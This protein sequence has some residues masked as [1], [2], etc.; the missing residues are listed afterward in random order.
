M[1]KI[2]TLG[3]LT[4]QINGEP[5]TSFPS[6]KAEALLVY[7]AV[8]RTTKHR[9]ESLFTL[10]WPGMP[11]KSARHNLRQ[12]LYAL[13][14]TL[15]EVAAAEGDQAVPLLLTDR[16]TVQINPEAAVIIDVQQ[17][18]QILEEIQG[19]EHLNLAGCE[20]CLRVMEE[21]V[22]RYGGEFLSD[23]YLEDSNEFE[24]W[25]QANREAYHQ[26]ALR[27]LKSL[28]G[29]FIQK[30]EYEQA[31]SYAERQLE[32]DALKESAHRQKMEILARCGQRA[33]ALCHYRNCI[34]ILRKELGI[35]PS[36]KTIILSEQ[37]RTES[38][39]A[40]DSHKA[41]LEHQPIPRHNLPHP[42]TS[43][44]GRQKELDEITRLIAN[45][46]LVTLT[47]AG[48]IG[49]TQ[50]CLQAGRAQ[51]AAFSDGV[52]LVEL[53]PIEKPH[54]IPQTIAFALGLW[55]SPSRAILEHLTKYLQD[56]HCLL[57]LD[58]CEHLIEAATQATEAILQSCPEVRI[59]ASSRETLSIPGEIVY[60]VPPLSFPHHDQHLNFE[61]WQQF[62]A[63]HLFAERARDVLA[64]FQITPANLP[65]LARS[66][67]RLDGIPLALELAAA[68]V[69]LLSLEQIAQRLNDRFSL[70]TESSRTAPQRQ[71]TLHNSIEWSW[72]LLTNSEQVLLQRL[73]VFAGGMSLEAVEAVCGS[74]GID[75]GE[76]MNLLSQ[77][78]NKSM[79]VVRREQGQETR[80]R[81]LETIHQYA[82]EKLAET[83]LEGKF[84]DR[85]LDYFLDL[86][87]QAEVELIGP[88]QVAWYSLLEM[89]I[90][91][92]RSA[93]SWSSETNIE[94]GLRLIT[95]LNRF[96]YYGYEAEGEAWIS[97]LLS[98]GTILEPSTR[99][100]AFWV[101]GILTYSLTLNVDLAN[102][103]LQKSLVLYQALEDQRGIALC[104]SQLSI[105]DE[106][107]RRELLWESLNIFRKI[108]DKVGA[109]GALLSLGSGN[110]NQF[111]EQDMKYREESEKL[112]REVG[113][114]TGIS[115]SL[116]VN[117]IRAMYRGE[118][119]IA[120]QFLEEC[121]KIQKLFGSKK[122]SWILAWLGQLY[123]W[124]NDY[125]KALRHLEKSLSIT[126]QTGNKSHHYWTMVKL[127]YVYLR[128]GEAYQAHTIFEKCQEQFKEIEQ[129]SG[130]IFST[131]G[132]ASLALSQGQA[133]K[134][135][136]LF[137]WADATRL[138]IQDTRPPSS[139]PM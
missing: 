41:T 40:S 95:S 10:L 55:E 35:A 39:P 31:R 77:L 27:T 26:K 61:D 101:Q 5:I 126:Q 19:H 29:I 82:A 16:H 70:L 124:K 80:Y 15:G 108:G 62:D 28:T 127:G 86:A 133:E 13:R 32:M 74:D 128:M 99:A 107:I 72:E 139:K 58:N 88:D 67:Q 106:N 34:E 83:K 57:L 1:L 24:D 93:L 118:F 129:M 71:Q 11:E 105:Y 104:W 42:L 94:A 36:T 9:R 100:K 138:E 60:L 2:L 78:V 38:L 117:G 110:I 115:T 25:V 12:V 53:A 23:F 85:H 125:Q 8:E 113:H 30:G 6:H 18:D 73:S 68:R 90:D 43:F 102:E 64:G 136:R 21:A 45:H 47:G 7:L 120:L 130:V 89:D 134:A 103:L 122:M 37:I 48:G 50:L 76:V 132:L 116:R 20:I 65:W 3:E 49:K 4:F 92:I 114:L 121:F 79:V 52:W 69:N 97:K 91:N 137:G 123:Y 14:Q 87:K 96:L 111:S 44:I 66:C 22:D 84:R 81:M 75:P 63:M 46:R 119:D 17:L 33:A 131:E 135:A 98:L 54:L 59:L 56:K 112:Y 109:A 51:L